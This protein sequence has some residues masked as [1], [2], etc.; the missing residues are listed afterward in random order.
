MLSRREREKS[1]RR[2]KGGTVV[3]QGLL[4]TILEQY[5]RYLG[6]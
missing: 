2:Y 3:N 1:Q 4:G 5:K 6:G